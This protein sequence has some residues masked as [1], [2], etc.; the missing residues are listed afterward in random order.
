MK[1]DGASANG[2]GPNGLAASEK[3]SLYFPLSPFGSILET[4]AT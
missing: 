3:I 2:T 1:P 4:G